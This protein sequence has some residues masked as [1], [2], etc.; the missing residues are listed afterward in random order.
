MPL[1]SPDLS[2][3]TVYIGF[4]I[5]VLMTC[6]KRI[7]FIST[8]LASFTMWGQA[9]RDSAGFRVGIYAGYYLSGE[10]PA[11]YYAGTDNNRLTNYLNDRLHRPRIIEALGN[12]DF[13]LAESA[14]DMVYNNSFA[15]ELSAELLLNNYWYVLTRIMNT[16]LTAS[17]IFTLDVQR[18]NQGGGF[19]N[20]LEQVSIGGT[21]TRSHIDIGVGKQIPIG[22]N[23][24]MLI[25][26]GFDLNFIEVVSNEFFINEQKFTLPVFTDPLNPQA[27]PGNTVGAGFYGLAGIGYELPSS[28]G[29]WFK[30]NYQQTNI[31]INRVIE[32]ST[33]IITPSV[34]FTKYF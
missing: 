2:I 3:K 10:G 20:N 16:R 15:F 18:G 32:E 8:L 31:N 21:E 11:R 25:E 26:G 19:P 27:S 1:V 9:Q 22:T 6:A 5:I 14:Q 12:Y 30:V 4:S 17:G 13:T 23:V 28:Y 24:Y 29:F 34:G 7:L 33:T